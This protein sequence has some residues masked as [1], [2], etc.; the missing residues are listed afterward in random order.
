MSAVLPQ[1]FVLAGFAA[2]LIPLGLFSFQRA[3]R[4]AQREGTLLHF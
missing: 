3:L 1:L 4:R 2:T